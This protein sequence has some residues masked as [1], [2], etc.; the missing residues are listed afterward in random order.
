MLGK[1]NKSEKPFSQVWL[2]WY[3]TPSMRCRSSNTEV[4]LTVKHK[5][6]PQTTNTWKQYPPR[7]KAALALNVWKGANRLSINLN[8]SENNSYLIFSPERASR[9]TLPSPNLDPQSFRT[10]W[11]CKEK[12]RNTKPGNSGTYRQTHKISLSFLVRSLGLFLFADPLVP[13]N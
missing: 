10:W 12:K 9:S 7:E 3:A 11:I 13:P 1:R 2:F 6:S 5:H 4:L 8:L